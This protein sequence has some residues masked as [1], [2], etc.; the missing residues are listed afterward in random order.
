MGITCSD[1]RIAIGSGNLKLALGDYGSCMSIVL[2]GVNHKTAPVEVRERLAFADARLGEA[3]QR[4]VDHSVISEGLIVSTCNRVEVI[5]ATNQ[6]EQAALNQLHEFLQHYHHCEAA[7]L[8][9]H[10]YQHAAAGAIQHIFRVTAALDS[11]VIGEPQITGQIKEAFQRAQAANAVGG[12]LTRLM[13]RAFAVA[14]RVRNETGIGASAVSISFVAVELARKIFERMQDAA[15]MLIGAGEMAELAARHLLNYGANK[16]LIV[17]RTYETAAALAQEMNGEPVRWEDFERRLP[18]AEVVICS[19]GAPHYLLHPTHVKHAL[20]ARRNRP[21]LLIDISVPRNID[22]AT[23]ALDNAFVFDVDDL[24]AIA[25]TNR[26]DRAREAERAE[27]IIAAETERFVAALAEG[28][29]HAVIG[30]FRREVSALAF[31]E[32]ERSRKRLGNLS[33]EQEEAL[34]VMLNAIV[35]KFTQPVIKQ[36]R[37]SEDGHSPYLATWRELYHKPG[38]QKENAERAE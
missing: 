22:P 15:V 13:N 26:A 4:L 31:A 1:E 5:A 9:K 19:T 30:A 38:E 18:E 14:K 17:N 20:E 24:E 21:M 33:A 12:T 23:G 36:L 8:H 28:D 2:I 25:N 11:M 37:A 10:C 6:S 3:L 34:R 35:N 32:L 7:L 27:T 16:I 29:M